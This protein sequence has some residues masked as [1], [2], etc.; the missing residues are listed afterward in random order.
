MDTS[1]GYRA[2][3]APRVPLDEVLIR[4]APEGYHEEFEADGLNVGLGGLSVRAAVLPE[5]GS[6]LCCEFEAQGAAS[7]I[8]VVGE[9]VWAHESGPYVGEFGV[10]FAELSEPDHDRIAELIYQWQHE[11]RSDP[12]RSPTVRLALEGVSSPIVATVSTENETG[13]EVEQPLPFLTIGAVVDNETTGRRGRL[14]GVELRLEQDTPRLVLTIGYD[15]APFVSEDDA[16]DTIPDAQEV[17]SAPPVVER[18]VPSLTRSQEFVLGLVD[19][20]KARLQ[21]AADWVSTRAT[22]IWVVIR[23]RIYPVIRDATIRAWTVSWRFVGALTKKLRGEPKRRKQRRPGEPL[24]KPRLLRWGLIAVAL[25]GVVIGTTWWLRADAPEPTFEPD[26]DEEPPVPA[27]SVVAAEPV[28]ATQPSSDTK[29]SA[30]SIVDAMAFGATSVPRGE[31]FV[32]RMSNPVDRLEGVAESGGFSVTIPNSLSLSRAGPIAASHPLVERSI[33]L[34][35]GD[36]SEFTL[37]F[38]EGH[39]PAYR[40]EAVGSSIEITIER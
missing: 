21:T 2:P 12:Q 37:R 15:G 17:A 40:V 32:L 39:S 30:P 27:P 11:T 5:V 22:S 31:K 7:P 34:N 25:S 1:V 38:V 20:L 13:M 4:L 16:M 35:R 28:E 23:G 33:I 3:R 6:R 10:R 29:G 9:V 14:S 19:G 36:Y 24:R 18:I 8:R 26:I